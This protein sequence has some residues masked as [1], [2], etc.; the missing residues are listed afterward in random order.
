L[1]YVMVTETVE[2]MATKALKRTGPPWYFLPYFLAGALPW[3][4]VA[5]F[6]WKKFRKPDPAVVYWLMAFIIPFVFF[7]INQSKRPQYIVPLMAPLALLIA[8]IWPEAKTR[9][10][11]ILITIFGV[12]LLAAPLAF[13][14]T[15]MKPEI[16]AVADET[17]L[18][19]GVAFLVAGLIAIVVKRRDVLLAAL[20]LPMLVLPIAANPLL[21]TLGERRSTRSFVAEMRPHITPSTHIIGVEAFTGSLAFYLRRPVTVITSDASELT[22]NYL[23][24]RYEKYTT[25]PASPLKPLPYFEQTLGS[26][27]PRVYVLRAKDVERR[28]VLE[29]RGW[30]MI[31]DQAHLVAYGK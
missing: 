17:A 13:H 19:L 18:A 23:I 21:N 7:S 15:K 10:A 4:I 9:A 26:T 30:R 31:A 11:A 25:N 24:R 27:E 2:R 28:K 29:S 5:L 1:R 8:R 20:S 16:A 22:S 6:S 3:S 12:I 14:R